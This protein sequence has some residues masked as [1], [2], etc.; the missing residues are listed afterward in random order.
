MVPLFLN[1]PFSLR[2]MP[3]PRPVRGVICFLE[4]G[5]WR[6]AISMEEDKGHIA[7]G[8]SNTYKGENSKSK[9]T[10]DHDIRDYNTQKKDQ[11]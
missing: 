9:K 3:H 1:P 6:D 7:S 11:S 8:Q 10:P 4:T 2:D 5:F